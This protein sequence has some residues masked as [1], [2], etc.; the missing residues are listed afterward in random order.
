[1]PKKAKLTR[2]EK[3]KTLKV[4][5]SRRTK[6]QVRPQVVSFRVTAV[7]GKTLEAIFKKDAAC[8]INSENQLAR[9]VVCDYLAGRLVYKNESDR[10][11]DL[12]LAES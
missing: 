7:Q 9:K 5:R 11:K 12:S 6:R 10:K 3:P 4:V 8:G 2:V 1:M